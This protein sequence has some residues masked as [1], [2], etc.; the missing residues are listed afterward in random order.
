MV[1]TCKV[2][3]MRNAEAGRLISRGSLGVVTG[4]R[5][6]IERLTGSFGGGPLEKGRKV[7]RWRPT[8]PHV[9]FLGGWRVVTLSGYPVG[10]R[11]GGKRYRNPPQRWQPQQ[12]KAQQPEPVASHLPRPNSWEQNAMFT[13]SLSTARRT[14]DKSDITEEPCAG[15]LASTVLE[16][17]QRGD[18]L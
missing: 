2:R 18:P 12:Q 7:P 14:H 3:K 1:R 15:K 10:G 16:T 17:S 6:E 9:R 4:E 5:P 11:P 13:M 8:L